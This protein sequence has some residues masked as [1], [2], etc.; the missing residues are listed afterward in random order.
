M[1][2]VPSEVRDGV[3]VEQDGHLDLAQ[4]TLHEAPALVPR[5]RARSHHERGGPP[6]V[7]RVSP[8]VPLD[9]MKPSSS[10]ATP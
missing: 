9:A 7:L 8:P 1:T 3:G 10:S 2:S 6:C 4:D 5:A